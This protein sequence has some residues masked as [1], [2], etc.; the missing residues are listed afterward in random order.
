MES[1]CKLRSIETQWPR[2]W[3]PAMKYNRPCAA[4]LSGCVCHLPGPFLCIFRHTED[5][6][7]KGQFK[8]TTWEHRCQPSW[9]AP[10][11]TRSPEGK[12]F[13]LARRETGHGQA[14]VSLTHCKSR[15]AAP[16]PPQPERTDSEQPRFL[17]PFHLSGVSCQLEAFLTEH[18]L[19]PS[20]QL[21]WPTAHPPPTPCSKSRTLF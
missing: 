7:L 11:N 17:P 15:A 6:G 16:L 14:S 12:V 4:T 2:T 8:R 19:K 13:S 10:H 9:A 3:Q 5:I 20:S 21:Y 18:S 1:R